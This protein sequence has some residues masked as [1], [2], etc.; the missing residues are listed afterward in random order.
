MTMHLVWTTDGTPYQYRVTTRYEI[1]CTVA[2]TVTASDATYR[3]D[4]VAGQRDHSWGVRDW[5]SIDWMWSALHLSDGT[6]LHGLDINIPNVPPIGIGYIQDPAHHVTELHT[7]TNPRAFAD[8]GY[9][10]I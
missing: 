3:M 2:G 4:S 9:R 6:H 1:P 10:S 7:V 5:W 8:N